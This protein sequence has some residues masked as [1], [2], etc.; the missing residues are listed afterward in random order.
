MVLRG[1]QSPIR[2]R[3]TFFLN[4]VLNAASAWLS[5]APDGKRLEALAA[6]R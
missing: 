2:G 5:G 6:K 3:R 1:R 4:N